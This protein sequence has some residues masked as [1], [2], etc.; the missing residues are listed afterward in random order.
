MPVTRVERKTD[1]VSRA[2]WLQPFFENGQI[3]FPAKHLHES[4]D[5]WQALP[6]RAHPVPAG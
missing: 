1:K 4:A 2:Y 3:V 6:R 5:E